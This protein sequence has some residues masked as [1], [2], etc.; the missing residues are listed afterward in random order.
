MFQHNTDVNTMF[1]FNTPVI[2]YKLK[3]TLFFDEPYKNMNSLER[4]KIV[5]VLF[6]WDKKK[7]F[8]MFLKTF[9]YII[10]I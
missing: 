9:G 7:N 1:C 5:N 4:K 3:T 8:I 2:F 6:H 10:M